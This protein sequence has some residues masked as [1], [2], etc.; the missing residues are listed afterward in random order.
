MLRAMKLIAGRVRLMRDMRGLRTKL[1]SRS[2]LMSIV[3][4]VASMDRES[5][6]SWV[7]WTISFMVT[8]LLLWVRYTDNWC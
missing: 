4:V 8:G 3:G 5:V 2:V 6:L 1:P 7:R